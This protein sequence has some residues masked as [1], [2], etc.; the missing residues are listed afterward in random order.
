MESWV[1]FE[2]FSDEW[3]DD[4]VSG[5]NDWDRARRVRIRLIGERVFGYSRNGEE[6]ETGVKNAI[7]ERVHDS[8]KRRETE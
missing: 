6:E 8:C 5:Q 2:S 1:A 3:A 7:Y 4:I